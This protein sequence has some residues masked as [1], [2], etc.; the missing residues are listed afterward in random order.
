MRWSFYDL[1][2][3]FLTFRSRRASV[4]PTAMNSCT[5]CCVVRPAAELE[6]SYELRAQNLKGEILRLTITKAMHL[7]L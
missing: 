7:G 5:S 1:I 6:S 2:I 3:V 4:H